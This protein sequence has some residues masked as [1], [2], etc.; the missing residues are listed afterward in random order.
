MLVSRE[1]AIPVT[2]AACE[3]WAAVWELR[4]EDDRWRR[5]EWVCVELP[6]DGEVW[7]PSAGSFRVDVEEAVDATEA[8][9]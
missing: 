4:L 9:C 1:G 3:P 7:N 2:L 8:V 6:N 5:D